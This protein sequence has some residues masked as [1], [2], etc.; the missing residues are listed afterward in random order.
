MSLYI[1]F[2]GVHEKMAQSRRKDLYPCKACQKSFSRYTKLQHHMTFHTVEENML[3]GDVFSCT[4]SS[5]K[6]QMRQV[7]RVQHHCAICQKRYLHSGYYKKHMWNAHEIHV[8]SIPLTVSKCEGLSDGCKDSRMVMKG[9]RKDRTSI[10][11]KCRQRNRYECS[12][13]RKT[14]TQFSTLKAHQRIHTG[15]RPY[16]CQICSKTFTFYQCLWNHSWSHKT[17]KSFPCDKCPKKY[18][19]YQNLWNHYK[20]HS[21]HK[22]FTCGMCKMNFTNSSE[23]IY[24]MKDHPEYLEAEIKSCGTRDLMT[25]DMNEMP[26]MCDIC[27][28]SFRLKV[29]LMSHMKKCH[30]FSNAIKPQLSFQ[31]REK[32]KDIALQENSTGLAPKA[33]RGCGSPRKSATKPQMSFQ[34]RKKHKDIALQEN[35]TGPAPKPKRGCCR[36]RKHTGLEKLKRDVINKQYKK[37]MKENPICS[38]CNKTS[39]Y[40]VCIAVLNDKRIFPESSLRRSSRL[41]GEK[42]TLSKCKTCCQWFASVSEYKEHLKQH[43]VTNLF[44]C[45]HCRKNYKSKSW[46]SRH[47]Y[48]IHR[49]TLGE[50]FK[51]VKLIKKLDGKNNCT[52][53]YCGTRFLSYSDYK[54][55]IFCQSCTCGQQFQC[56]Y[57]FFSHA[58][59]CTGSNAPVWKGPVDQSQESGDSTLIF[60][61]KES[62]HDDLLNQNNNSFAGEEIR[63]ASHIFTAELAEDIDTND[64][65]LSSPP[66]ADLYMSERWC[67]QLT[68]DSY[69]SKNLPVTATIDQAKENGSSDAGDTLL[70]PR[71][72]WFISQNPWDVPQDPL[73]TP[74]DK[75]SASWDTLLVRGDP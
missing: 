59:K 74:Q 61:I 25:S 50:S 46:L 48:F 69:S 26:F 8:K 13:C 73:L 20:V 45:K 44:K 54:N 55:H 23:L 10:T 21:D 5:P 57:I 33:K 11:T 68:S 64:S 30:S 52:C 6:K 72:P 1:G 70:V 4:W 75:L 62:V 40:C 31:K 66:S 49:D 63:E 65:F 47:L 16:Q 27:C 60:R 41:R 32:C 7:K 42:L 29:S 38:G 67:M 36:P 18:H 56:A 2:R 12:V 53:S 51:K 9:R 43:A 34:R 71:N 19:Y 58:S 14:M 39:T 15:E 24:H 37:H 3:Y 35:S 22:L 17:Q 28:R